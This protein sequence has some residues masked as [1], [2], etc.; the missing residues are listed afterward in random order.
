MLQAAMS[1]AHDPLAGKWPRATPREVN[2]PLS[3]CLKSS[4]SHPTW[5]QGGGRFKETGKS[6]EQIY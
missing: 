4:P 6:P 5:S 2:L 3:F 1:L